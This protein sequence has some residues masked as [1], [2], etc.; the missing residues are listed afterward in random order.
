MKKK[1]RIVVSVFISLILAVSCLPA[2][3]YADDGDPKYPD[4]YAWAALSGR[5]QLTIDL[6][7]YEVDFPKAGDK[8]NIS[9]GGGGGN[10]T[11]TAK[12][13]ADGNCYFE[14]LE[15]YIPIDTIEYGDDH[16]DIIVWDPS[17]DYLFNTTVSVSITA[18]TGVK[19]IQYTQKAIPKLYDFIDSSEDT[20]DGKDCV[21][22]SYDPDYVTN[23]GDT[24][25]VTYN[26]NT[27]GNYTAKQVDEV[28]L[29]VNDSDPDDS[30]GISFKDD[31]GPS[32]QWKAGDQE[33]IKAIYAGR[34]AI[35]KVKIESNPISS[36]VFT[37]NGYLEFEKEDLMSGGV[38]DLGKRG[39]AI[40]ANDSHTYFFRHGEGLTLKYNTSV[41]GKTEQTYYYDAG[42]KDFIF[43]VNGGIEY[44]PREYVYAVYGAGVVGDNPVYIKYG[45]KVSNTINVRITDRN[46]IYDSSIAKVK[47]SKPKTA[48]KSLT[49]KWKKLTKKQLKKGKATHYE[50]WA[51]KDGAFARGSTTE[52]V[53]KKSKSS[54][55]IKGLAKGTYFVKVRA[56][57]YVNGAKYVGAWSKTKRVKVKK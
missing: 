10:R 11:Y 30:I 51:C 35:I 40:R 31:Q 45:G 8:I 28:I 46:G 34:T 17:N 23:I 29:F 56:I 33:I 38:I 55:K 3:V 1:V 12:K 24:L 5:G 6:Q 22:F 16:V 20:I 15:Y 18:N 42:A 41:R 13:D 9:L 44:I 7:T 47:I 32:N 26:D 4:A 36:I 19:S 27:V 49:A 2:P 21:I 52:R 50:I 53:V 37:P 54:L 14:G 25:K 39:D 43:C 57:K 48:K